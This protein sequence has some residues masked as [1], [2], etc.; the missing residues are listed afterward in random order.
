MFERWLTKCIF[1][2]LE[3]TGRLC[4]V[5]TGTTGVRH[6]PN[7]WPSNAALDTPANATCGTQTVDVCPKYSAMDEAYLWN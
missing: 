2:V 6:I 4:C 5:A 1:V 7:N 3:A